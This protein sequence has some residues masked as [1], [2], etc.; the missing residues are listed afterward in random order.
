[1]SVKRG[2][3]YNR[4]RYVQIKDY[5]G[6]L[7]ERNITPTD[8]DG[9]LEFGNKIFVFIEIKCEGQEMPDGQ[10]LALTRLVD[11]VERA[12]KDAALI[13]ATHKTKED[14]D[15]DCANAIVSKRYRK[16]EWTTPFTAGTTLKEDIDGFLAFIRGSKAA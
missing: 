13:V 2:E 10:E 9:L 5:S 3:A 4:E 11:D 14:D 8:I 1:M 6:L 16:G 7:F 12:G 15:I